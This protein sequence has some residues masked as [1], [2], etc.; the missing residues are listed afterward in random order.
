MKRIV[1]ICVTAL[2]VASCSQKPSLQKY[3]V[4]KTEDKNFIALDVSP[5]ILNID[6]QKLTAEQNEALGTFNKMN[7]L[8][9]KLTDDNKG[10]YESE[11][12][13]VAGILKDKKY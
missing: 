4:E 2:L 6:K 12:A 9:F 10:Q 7:I 8:A 13:K 3:F 5:T 1:I 11:K